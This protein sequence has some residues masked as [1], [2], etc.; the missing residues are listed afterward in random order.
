MK[1]DTLVL[2]PIFKNM[3]YYFRKNNVN[4]FQTAKLQPEGVAQHLLDFLS[5]SAWHCL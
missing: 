4:N 1:T 3:P 2:S 5:I